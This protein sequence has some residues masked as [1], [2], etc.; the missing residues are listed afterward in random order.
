VRIPGYYDGVELTADDRAVLARTGDDEPAIQRKIGIA[1]PERVGGNFQEALQ[2][3]SLNVRGMSSAA[4]GAKA[5]NIVP[6]EAVAELGVRPTAETDGRR[7]F[8]LIRRHIEARGYHLTEG[9]PTD[10]DRARHD[11]LA[12]L[13]LGPVQAAA[14][15][16]IDSPVGRW[17]AT[18]LGDPVRIRMMGGTV[19]TAVLLDALHLPFLL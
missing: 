16:P 7:L 17:A 4:V 3:P 19:P 15:M 10:A 9:P 2:Y 11:K 8:E 13:R 6:S 5:A 14:R 18:A 1:R 12:S